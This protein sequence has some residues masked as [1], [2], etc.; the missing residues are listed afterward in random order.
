MFENYG[1]S[2]FQTK[3]K[4][5]LPSKKIIGYRREESYIHHL[6]REIY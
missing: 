2:I 4:L 1:L 6:A 3:M 5:K